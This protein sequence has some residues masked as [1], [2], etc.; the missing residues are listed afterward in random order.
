M[1][2]QLEHFPNLVAMF[3][4]RAEEKGDAPLLWAKRGGTWLSISW[5]EAARQVAGL[6]ASLRRIGM[7]P[8]DRVALVSENRPE[9]LIADL[10]IMA[11]GC[12][13]VPTYTTNTTRDHTHILGN[14]G[15]R[16]VI[17]SNHGGRQLDSAV[18][19]LDAL[20]AVVEAVA[21]GGEVLL[22]GGIRRGT[23]VLKALA[24]GARAV[25]IGRPVYWGLA[26]GGGAGVRH[27]LELLRAELALD[28]MLCGL[29]SLEEVTRELLVPANTLVP[30]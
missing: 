19:S 21:G 14:S 10:G 16:A 27:I 1:A 11:A 5:N 12:V 4:A 8:G 22:D 29:A 20:P 18:A 23:D 30:A 6:A 28:L 9:W 17:V 25:L 15:A 3:L 13:T 24:L 7:Q 26:A 2:R